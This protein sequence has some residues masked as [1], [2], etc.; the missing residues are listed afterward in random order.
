[1]IES[2]RRNTIAAQFASDDAERSESMETVRL[3]AALSKPWVAPPAGH[4][5]D[6]KLPER[7]QSIG[8]RGINNA[9][10]LMLLALYPPDSP[11]F[12][13]EAAAE[14]RYD[15]S[16]PPE[17]QNA[18]LDDLLA[19]ELTATALLESV[20]VRGISNRRQ[21]AF[22]SNKRQAISQILI[23][24]DSLERMNPDYSLTVFQREAYVSG[25]DCAGNV[26][27]HITKECKD[28]FELSDE[29]FGNADLNRMELEERPRNKRTVNLYTLCEWQPRDHTWKLTQEINGH[30]ISEPTEDEIS[31]YIS[32]PYELAPGDNYGHGLV[33]QNLGDLRSLNELQERLL[34]FAATFSKILWII[35]DNEM[36]LRPKDLT[37]KTGSVARGRVRGGKADSI[38]T[39]SATNSPQFQLVRIHAETLKKD[40]ARAFL[41]ESEI[42]PQKE[43]VTAQ[44]IQRIA[45]EIE[46]SLGGV[47]AP[48]AESQ[49]LQTIRRTLWQMGRDKIMPKLP[50]GLVDIRA[51]TGLS[52]LRRESERAKLF[53]LTAFMQSLPPQALVKIDFSTLVEAA[54]R[55]SVID[56]PGLIKSDEQVQQ[57]QQQQQQASAQAAAANKTIDVAGNVAQSALTQPVTTGAA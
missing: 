28:P 42:Q 26:N 31:P 2:N 47:Y 40:L 19:R 7:F 48:I 12:Q 9:E 17:V 25:R 6:S 49:Q 11:W 33:E 1:M 15:R 10:G 23:T 39:I 54:I 50:E 55:L 8:P 22:R 36:T 37:K 38:A 5:K 45:S 51:L 56:V 52:A 27:Y 13:L 14:I 44:Q 46:G 34:D 24:G 4:S 18:I 21:Q 53:N 30:I 32:T 35:D 41:I 20:S 57:E 16:I 29:E 43:R 3:A